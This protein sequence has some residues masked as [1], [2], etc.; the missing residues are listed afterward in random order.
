MSLLSILIIVFRTINLVLQVY[1]WGMIVYFL[2]SWFPGARENAFGRFLAKIYEPFL[3]PF[4]RVI[5][6]IG[7]LDI[8]SLVAFFT[9]QLFRMGVNAIFNM[10]ITHLY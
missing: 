2:M 1:S 6:P 3:D 8:S 4:R 5:P 9:L 7:M 10:I